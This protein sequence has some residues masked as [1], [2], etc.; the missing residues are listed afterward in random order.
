MGDFILLEGNIAV[1]VVGVFVQ[2]QRVKRLFIKAT[3]IKRIPGQEDKISKLP[4]YQFESSNL[5]SSSAFLVSN[6]NNAHT[7]SQS[8]ANLTPEFRTEYGAYHW[9]GHQLLPP[10][11]C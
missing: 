2:L 3:K 7:S 9:L 4:V 1:R 10:S 11:L 5:R 6:R 8:H